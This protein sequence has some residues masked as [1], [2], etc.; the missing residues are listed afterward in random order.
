MHS[1]IPNF[2]EAMEFSKGI[3]NKGNDGFHV[4]KLKRGPVLAFETSTS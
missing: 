2:R 1:Q 3:S 4:W